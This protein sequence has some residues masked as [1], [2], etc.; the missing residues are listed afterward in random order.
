[1]AK[2]AWDKN[3]NENFISFHAAS[4]W[5]DFNFGNLSLMRLKF[6][7]RAIRIEPQAAPCNAR[8]QLTTIAC[9]QD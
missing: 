7:A 8:Q 3:G 5:A 6:V 2:F 9:A 4:F 1:M